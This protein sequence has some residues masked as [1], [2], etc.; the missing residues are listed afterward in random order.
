[1]RTWI[2]ALAAALILVSASGAWAELVVKTKSGKTYSVPVS[3]DEI[4][5][6]LFTSGGGFSTSRYLGCYRDQGEP[7]G[8]NGRDLN[9]FVVNDGNMSTAFCT[10]TCQGKGFRYAATQY[11]SWCFCGNSYGR[12]GQADNCNMKCAGNPAETC[13]GS[14]ANSVYQLY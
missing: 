12:S 13:G 5:S 2:A 1:M 10:S 7:T 3:A 4:E 14:W 11:G 9:G 8:T 6:I